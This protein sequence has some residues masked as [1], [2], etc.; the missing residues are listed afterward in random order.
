MY[1]ILKWPVLEFGF[2]YG[3]IYL[4]IYHF[5]S[6][7]LF[8]LNKSSSFLLSLLKTPLTLLDPLCL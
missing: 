6:L 3:D 4:S 1:T 5:C 7:L 8:L 2:K